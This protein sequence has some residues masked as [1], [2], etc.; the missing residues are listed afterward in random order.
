MMQ[1][2]DHGWNSPPR[3]Q[4]PHPRRAGWLPGWLCGLLLLSACGGRLTHV[5]KPILS[6]AWLQVGHLALP[7]P[8]DWQLLAGPPA[9]QAPVP[10]PDCDCLRLDATAQNQVPNAA[11]K[12]L[13]RIWTGMDT[14]VLDTTH[15]VLWP[16]DCFEPCYLVY[17]DW[18]DAGGV[19]RLLQRQDALQQALAAHKIFHRVFPSRNTRLL[20]GRRLTHM[21]GDSHEAGRS[22]LY[23]P[24]DPRQRPLNIYG[25]HLSKA[26]IDALRDMMLAAEWRR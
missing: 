24:G 3:P 26:T 8:A 15:I 20:E 16:G 4:P 7:W 19:K 23:F 13:G 14:L 21:N 1:Q 25:R 6:G 9:P 2:S 18:R 22:G 12:D 11:W 5:T 17:D 10:D